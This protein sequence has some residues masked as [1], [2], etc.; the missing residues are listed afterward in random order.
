MNHLMETITLVN[1]LFI[2]HCTHLAVKSCNFQNQI[3]NIDIVLQYTLSRI[4]RI[5]EDVFMA[6]FRSR[7]DED[8]F[9]AAFHSCVHEEQHKFIFRENEASQIE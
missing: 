4:L 5:R 9:M 6:A 8:V 1:K 2:L 3:L 7:V